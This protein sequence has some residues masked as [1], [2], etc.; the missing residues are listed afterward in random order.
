MFFL[1]LKSIIWEFTVIPLGICSWK[2]I[3]TSFLDEIVG[4]LFSGH[5]APPNNLTVSLG[6]CAAQ[7]PT[8]LLQHGKQNLE[9]RPVL[10]QKC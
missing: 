1:Q 4:L 7:R 5:L 2:L 10:L 6:A 9:P 8:E 3:F